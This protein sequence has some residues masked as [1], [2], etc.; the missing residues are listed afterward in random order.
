VFGKTTARL[1]LRLVI[2]F[3]SL[4]AFGGRF[5]GVLSYY[6]L[7]FY[8]QKNSNLWKT[9]PTNLLPLW[10]SNLFLLAANTHSGGG[11]NKISPKNLFS[12]TSPTIFPILFCLVASL[13]SCIASLHLIV[14]SFHKIIAS[15]RPISASVLLFSA[16]CHLISTSLRQAS[17]SIFLFFASLCQVYASLF[18]TTAS[19]WLVVASIPDAVATPICFSSPKT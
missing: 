8:Y 15:Y 10:I 1:R 6:S 4:S 5:S 17:A 18:V 14:T 2:R 7:F 12:K 19:H 3:K 9:I 16:S 11:G 13:S